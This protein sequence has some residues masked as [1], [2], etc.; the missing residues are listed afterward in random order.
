MKLLQK[1]LNKF[2]GLHYPQEYLCLSPGDLVQPLHVYLFDG[3]RATAD[4]TDLHAFVGYHPLILALPSVPGAGQDVIEILFTDKTLQPNELFS[5]KDAIAWLQLK[6]IDA[7]AFRCPATSFYEGL[8][9]GHR[10]ISAASQYLVS[11]NN[12]LFNRKKGNVFLHAN[13]YKQV[14]IAYSL[15]RN[16]SLIT[17]G[18]GNSFNLFPTDLHGVPGNDKYIISLRFA[19]KACRQVE[20]AGKILLTQ[21]D[22]R[23]YK[24]VYGL[25]KNHMQDLKPAENFPFSGRLSEIYRLPV[26]ESAL[27]YRELELLDTFNHGI[28]KLMHFKVLHHHVATEGGEALSHVHNVY[29]TWRHNKGLPGNYLLR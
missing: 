16:I 25:G 11:L 13:L 26:P 3:T 28:H 20:N 4:I 1:V 7:P 10:F 24:T 18:Q 22:P 19:G 14:Q 9:G 23:F 21:V 29:A 6:K 5:K 27:S 12:R 15:P 2:N 8:R 17:V